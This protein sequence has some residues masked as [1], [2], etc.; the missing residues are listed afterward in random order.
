MID[1]EWSPKTD[2]DYKH[3]LSTD[4]RRLV[5]N[6]TLINKN[7]LSKYIKILKDKNLLVE[8]EFGGFEIN[9]MIRPVF[10]DN[11]VSIG[12]MLEI[13]NSNE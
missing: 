8:N 3:I 9:P 11:T 13:E 2:S 6:D 7:N 12:F 5:M 4:N 10:K 1:T